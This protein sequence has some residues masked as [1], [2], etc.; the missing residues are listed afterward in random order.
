M[1]TGI[2]PSAETPA[3]RP[4]WRNAFRAATGGTSPSDSKDT[5]KETPTHALSLEERLRLGKPLT[6]SELKQLAKRGHVVAGHTADD[7]YEEEG[8][9]EK[10]QDRDLSQSI[11]M[12]KL[13]DAI[14]RGLIHPF[15]LSH[16]KQGY[17]SHD[18]VDLTLAHKKA[19][20]E[21]HEV[22]LAGRTADEIDPS[23]GKA[24]I[25]DPKTGLQK[26]TLD[27]IHRDL[28]FSTT[29]L[30]R[31][32]TQQRQISTTF[33]GA[34]DYTGNIPLDNPEFAPP[35]PHIAATTLT[36]EPAAPALTPR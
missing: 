25:V 31:E 16:N 12:Q 29:S 33:S 20:E 14:Y 3:P 22:C 10:Q 30:A 8:A 19:I 24:Y 26:I 5:P 35:A 4:E 6:F 7:D 36:A 17:L 15:S 34:R 11:Q 1:L 9:E 18:G 32:E 13:F 23:T 21:K 28:G 2:T 27:D